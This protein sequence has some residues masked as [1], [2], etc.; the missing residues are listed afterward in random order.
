MIGSEK[1]RPPINA[2]FM[3]AREQ[4]LRRGGSAGSRTPQTS[5]APGVGERRRQEHQQPLAHRPREGGARHERNE[6]VDQ[7]APELFEVVPEGHRPIFFGF[8]I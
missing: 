8:V 1:I 6:H 3:Y 7:T 5:A 2:S 4:G